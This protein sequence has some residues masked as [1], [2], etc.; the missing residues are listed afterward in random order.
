LSQEFFIMRS[1][2]ATHLI[3]AISIACG[4]L[5]VL[6]AQPAQAA[7]SLS[8]TPLFLTVSVP[9]NVVLTLDDSGSMRRAFVPENCLAD[10]S[11]CDHLDNRYEKSARRNLIHYNPNVTYPQPEGPNGTLLTTSFTSAWRNGF[12]RTGGTSQT[13]NLATSYR[14]TAYLDLNAGAVAEEFMGHN[15]SDFRC[16]TTAGTPR[17]QYSLN[18]GSSWVT[19]SS[20][21]SCP[22]TIGNATARHNFCRGTH[23]TGYDPVG[24]PAYYY[25]FDPTNNAV[26]CAAANA[27]SNNACYDL[28][29]VTS[30]SGPG[31]TDERQNF[32]NW[33]S[34]ARTRNLATQ[35]AAS[36]AFSTLDPTVRVGW[37][38]LNS[39]NGGSSLIDT[40]CDGWKSNFS[41]ISNAIRP[42]T[43]THKSNFVSWVQQQ[44][45]ASGTPLPTAMA[46]V[47][48]Y[49]QTNGP[50][51]NEP[52]NSA[53]GQHACRR[54]YHIMMTD[55]IWTASQG[56]SPQDTSTYNLPQSVGTI[57]QYQPMAPYSGS[58]TDT[59]SDVA[60]RYS[61]TDLR[62]DLP[63][64]VT[65]I[66]RDTVGTEAQQFWNPKN[67]PYPWQ[68]MVNFTI[69]LGL[70]GYLNAAGLTWAGDTYTGSYPNIANGMTAWP[71]ANTTD[72]NPGNVAD[73]WHAAINSRGKFF[74]ADDPA[75]L[76][77]SF[78]DVLGAITG[79]AGSSAALSA[80]S[81]SIQ[82]GNTYVYQAKFNKDWSGTLLAFQVDDVT[83]TVAGADNW[84]ASENIPAWNLRNIFTHNGM[85]GVEFRN[86]TDLS[87]AQQLY[88]G[89]N[90]SGVADLYCQ[91]RL[92]WLRGSPA[93]EQSS[94]TG[95]SLRMFRNRPTN[96]MGDIINSDPAFVKAVDYGYSTLPDGI[97]GKSDYADYVSA[98]APE[99][100]GRLPMVYVGS[101]DGRLYGIRATVA[102]I[103]LSGAEQFSYVPAGVYEHLA[104]LTD[105]VYS[106]RFYVDGGITAGD[107]YLTLGATTAWR[108]IVTAGLNAGGK[109]IYALNVTDPTNFTANNVLWEFNDADMGYSFS[110]PQM[111]IM[112]DGSW[113]AVF[114]NGYNSTEGGAYLYI[115]NLAT[116]ALIRKIPVG[117]NIIGTDD[118]NGLSTPFLFDSDNDKMIDTIY[119][120]DLQ[121]N[122]W[123][124]DVSGSSGSWQAAFAG[125]PLF[126]ARDDSG[127]RQPITSQPKVGGHPLGG[128]MVVFGTGR[129][130]T[131]ADIT[132]MSVQTYYGIRDHGNTPVSTTDRSE[133][134]EQ[135]I[136][137]QLN[138]QFGRDVRSISDN[139]PD[140][141]TDRGWYLDLV[142]PV[143][144]PNDAIGERV[145]STSLI[146]LGRVIF[147]TITPSQDPCQPGGS[148]W[149]MELDLVNGGTFPES[150]LD[151]NN[152]NLFDA[153]DEVQGEVVSG[154]R[155]TSLGISKTPVWLD[156][157]GKAFKVLTGT[158]GSFVTEKN[159]TPNPPPPPSGEVSRRSWIQIR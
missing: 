56:G 22:T 135:T 100:G 33:Y 122:L 157:E 47:G 26:A 147:V 143:A 67:D 8:N 62:P 146:R 73:L 113:V 41:N 154:V 89:T 124:F 88:L 44:P 84:D 86:C 104:R 96:I 7:L 142:D 77:R 144:P 37:Q 108:T 123:K 128:H 150:I 133:L 12:D 132:D 111:G 101:N 148:S 57:T 149:L 42:F 129:Y 134:Q 21:V 95:G 82:P 116:G 118:N 83:G 2:V 48:G 65:P 155:N 28:R 31:G 66:I 32:A 52:G 5:T 94:T 158:R 36:L 145:V 120:G 50:Y 20:P 85:Q 107:A 19:P 125:A 75:S 70:T 90:S 115:V 153:L 69:G 40:D 43:G 27:T 138:N 54:N 6:V 109:S 68:H 114:G 34:F 93:D 99:T 87:V 49:F 110:Q 141:N 112:E 71:A 92:N 13:V 78:G 16:N 159:A 53:S 18:G 102:P 117:T 140:W 38:A 63:N 72:N 131:L 98:N 79:D 30:T 106:H 130:L 55:G 80:N 46:R 23:D 58:S 61:V 137:L 74:S 81:T 1:N 119:V 121:G 51:Y 139:V 91:N 4:A 60:F 45:T 97:P 3:R 10:S 105:P 17:C 76:A 24:M 151:L 14:P 15:A 136:S 29:L 35:T 103:A 126:Q 11:D 64:E 39:C 127:A 156:A 59:L 152:D 25:V 9:P